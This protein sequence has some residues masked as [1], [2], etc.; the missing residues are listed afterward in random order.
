MQREDDDLPGDP[1]CHAH[2]V[3]PAHMGLVDAQTA[4]DVQRWRR[5]ERQRL[6]ETRR[7]LAVSARKQADIALIEAL[8]ARLGALGR[9]RGGL[10]VALY[11][12]I[13]GEPDLRPWAEML[14]AQGAITLLPVV[15]R[16][17]TP[18]V[19]RRWDAG[20][21]LERGIW[22][23]PVPAADRPA[24][25]PDLVI[26]PV[27]GLGGDN[28]RLGYGGGYYDRTL[29]QLAATGPAPHAIGVGYA[30]QR[31]PTIYPLPHDIALS[32]A[33][34]A[35]P[36]ETADAETALNAEPR[37]APPMKDEASGG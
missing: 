7:A 18:L 5:A 10:R 16:P 2:L 9:D 28:Y 36:P 30:F 27:V 22:N 11:W 12:P 24:E 32:E 34:L 4:R 21:S 3:D 1:P 35:T 29:A 20:D 25:R 19:F 31:I 26:A 23:I 14:R 15:E 33:I 8:A 13:K 17:A 37:P 6:I